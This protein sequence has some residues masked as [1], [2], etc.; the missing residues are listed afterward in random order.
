MSEA[1]YVVRKM[2]REEVPFA[3]RMA[4]QEGWNPGVHDAACFYS[5]DPHGF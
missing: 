3:V 1:G 5:A 4:E 2:T